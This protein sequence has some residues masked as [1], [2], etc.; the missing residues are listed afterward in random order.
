MCIRDSFWAVQI[1]KKEIQEQGRIYD[2]KDVYKRQ[3]HGRVTADAKLKDRPARD[4]SQCHTKIVYEPT[5]HQKHGSNGTKAVT[6]KYQALVSSTNDE[7]QL[8]SN[9]LPLCAVEA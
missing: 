3:A 8:A 1:G 7:I 5:P 2:K 9:A 6:N 4:V